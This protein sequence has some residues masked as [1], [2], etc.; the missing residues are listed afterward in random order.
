[1]KKE[2]TKQSD[3]SRLMGYAGN[4]RYFTYASWVLSAVSALVALVPFVY[5]WKVLR[6]VLNAAPDYAQAV[7]I[8]HYGWMAVLFAVL[9]YLIYIAALMCSHLSAFRVAT[10]LRLEVSEHLAT[11][12]LGFTETFGSGKLRKI[13]HESTG[14]AE[15]F[16]AH[17]L[18]DKYNAMAT[19]IGL[20][21]LLLVFD[22]RLGLLS[23]V[24]V[25]LGFVIMSAMTGRRMADKMRQYGNAL[26]SM[27]NEAVEYV[28]GIPVVKTFGQSVF[29]FK[30]FKAT[31]DEYEKW[32]I[33]YTKE[34][35]MPMML[36]TAAIN[37]V[38]AFLI[39]GGLLFTRNGVTS[40]FLLN[41][42]FY[43]IITPVISLTLTR[44]M[45]MSENELVVADA[46]A[47]VDSVL[48]AE[49]VPEN[50]HPRHPKDASVSLKD[51]HFSYDGKTDVI[52]GVSLKIQPGQMVAFVGPS[53]GGKSTLANL[54][55]RFF[56]VQSGSVRVGG[57]DV[58]DIPKEELMDT[59][60]FVFQNSRL[61]KGSI[62]DNVRLGRAQAT[63]AEVLA[64]LKAAQCMDI[65]EKFPEG[66][67]TVIGTKGV[68]LSGGEQQRIAIAR[69][70]LKNAPILL[71]DEATAFADP[72]NEAKVQAA[73]AQLAKGKTVLMIAHRLS[74]VANADC[75]YVVQ[76]GQIVESGTKDEL[77]A[78]N[79]LF[80]RMWQDYQASVQ[81]KVAKEG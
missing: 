55:C 46:L 56:D 27:S 47:R 17:Q 30:K 43:I 71:L 72:D 52:K 62:L 81:W 29:S 2:E 1:M 36:Y 60:S 10:N 34:L 5:I 26:E 58:R 40:E 24:P 25:A 54:I 28:R 74:T 79:G 9:A 45:Y 78:Q 3:L 33:A 65:V 80:A 50:D 66:I 53:G 11:L 77:C 37:G 8:P 63:E 48:D 49:P 69:A 35:R 31:I 42:L 68:Y 4:Y 12:P 51:V 70:M 15:T 57:A 38:F 18:P 22:W 75:I 20:L 14:A 16:L 21:V 64:A 73:F 67:H 76:D 19:P 39:V 6:D 59:I 23:L 32:V 7:N 61:L 41:L 44:I 13:I